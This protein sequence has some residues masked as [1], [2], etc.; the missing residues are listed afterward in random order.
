MEDRL[1]LKPI[2]FGVALGAAEAA[3]FQSRGFF[4]SCGLWQSVALDATAFQ[5]S[6]LSDPDFFKSSFDR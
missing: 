1:G 6:A 2:F 3:P 5:I 4:Q